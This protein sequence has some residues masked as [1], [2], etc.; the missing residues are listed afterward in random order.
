LMLDGGADIR[1]IQEMLG[2][3][4]LSTTQIYTH[5]SLHSLQNI[6]T[7]THPAAATSPALAANPEPSQHSKG[8]SAAPLRYASHSITHGDG[9]PASRNKEYHVDRNGKVETTA[10]SS[11]AASTG[12]VVGVFGGRDAGSR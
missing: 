11:L 9:I 2:H 12:S 10:P 3:A 6:H 4:G 1:H 7:Q 5:I 8:I